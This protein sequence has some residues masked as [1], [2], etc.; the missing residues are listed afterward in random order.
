MVD[1]KTKHSTAKI[2]EKKW[3]I[4]DA[5][6]KVLGKVASTAAVLLRG[7]HK[8]QYS[9]HAEIGDYVIVIN[10]QKAI[11][12]GNKREQKMYHRHSGYPGSLK[13]ENYETLVKRKPTFPME[14]AIRGMLPKNRLGRKLMSNVKLY[15]DTTHPH[16]AQQPQAI[17]VSTFTRL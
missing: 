9:P 6:D 12:T 15:S 5:S 17:D 3:Y 4:I 11:L 13:S 1:Q 8:T 10:T 2:I 14:R 16:D 7:K